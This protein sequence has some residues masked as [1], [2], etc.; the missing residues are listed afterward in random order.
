MRLL[1]PRRTAKRP[2]AV[3]AVFGSGGARGLAHLGVIQALD[4]LGLE[5]AIVV[6]TSIGAIAAAAYATG[7]TR[8][9][10]DDFLSM[11]LIQTSRMFFDLGIP[12]SGLTEGKHVME[13]LRDW[14]PD[15]D[16][17]RLRIPFAAVAMD[18]ATQGEV[19][20][21]SGRILDAVRASISIP[22]VFSPV[23]R[24]GLWLVDGGLVNPLPVSVARGKGATRV[25]AVD[26]NLAAGAPPAEEEK[27]AAPETASARAMA[28][29]RR[30]VRGTAPFIVDVLAQS[31]RA[32]ENAIERERLL[33]D[34]PDLLLSPPVGHIGTLDFRNPE[35]ALQAGYDCAMAQADALRDLF[36][37]GRHLP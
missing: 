16:I 37:S 28:K 1:P 24:D 7:T 33:N 8:Q 21:D 17:G 20:L 31:L 18:L 9:V 36:S 29:L 22:G 2:P 32:G 15:L 26:I 12:R 25:L 10:R 19:V 30:A 3:A 11:N 5:P 35:A 4:E 6:G 13:K 23:P 34:A 27:P 14:I